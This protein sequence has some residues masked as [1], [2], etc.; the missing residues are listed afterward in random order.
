MAYWGNNPAWTQLSD[1]E[2]AAAM[3][4]LEADFRDGK[5]DIEG[6][7]N[8][9][10]AIINRSQAEGADLGDQ[11]SQRIYQPTIEDAQ[12]RRLSQVVGSPEHQELVA[13]AQRRLAGEE[14]DWVQGATHFLAPEETMLALEARNPSKYKNWGPRGANWTGYDPET[15]S[16]KGVVMRDR[17]HAF[18]APEG[19]KARPAPQQQQYA[20]LAVAPQSSAPRPEGRMSAGLGELPEYLGDARRVETPTPVPETKPQQ[21][22]S[23]VDGPLGLMPR[24]SDGQT[25]LMGF[26]DGGAV[27]MAMSAAERRLREIQAKED[28]LAE[29]EGELRSYDPGIADRVRGWINDI[30]DKA[31]IPKYGDRIGRNT[32]E[33]ADLATIA[34]T[35]HGAGRLMG[36]FPSRAALMAPGAADA[37]IARSMMA[38]AP[39]GATVAEGSAVATP[40]ARAQIARNHAIGGDPI[41]AAVMRNAPMMLPRTIKPT[42]G[43]WQGRMGPGGSPANINAGGR[44]ALN[45]DKALYSQRAARGQ[46]A[47]GG[48]TQPAQFNAP[49]PVVAPV[50]G[51]LKSKDGGRTDTLPITVRSGS[52]VLPADVVSHLGEGNSDAG[53]QVVHSIFYGPYGIKPLGGGRKIAGSKTTKKTTTKTYADGG[54]V[55]GPVEILAAGGEHVLPPEVIAKVGGGDLDHGFRTLDAF[56][57]KVRKDHIKTLKSLPPP[58]K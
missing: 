47:A 34:L 29:E 11:V 50:H 41:E 33:L 45:Y 12:F 7:R 17:G 46:Y 19:G 37:S 36:I 30:G 44:N 25:P 9:L 53:Q 28:A 2:R 22:A 6:A 42:I 51:P 18:L 26:A 49:P 15:G 55:G 40:M 32:E 35:A 43:R 48:M 5:I 4:L 1:F 13:L 24:W 3:A 52:F 58:A 31:G 27:D 54:S 8:V 14:P 38:F 23:W 16:Y 39:E 20:G 21:Q 56:V 57:K 10:G